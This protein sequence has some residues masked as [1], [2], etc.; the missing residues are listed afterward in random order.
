MPVVSEPP[1]D[2]DNNFVSYLD[3]FADIQQ[4]NGRSSLMP[5]TVDGSVS[6]PKGPLVFSLSLTHGIVNS[7]DIGLP[8]RRPISKQASPLI[9]PRTLQLRD[10]QPSKESPITPSDAVWRNMAYLS[11]QAASQRPGLKSHQKYGRRFRALKPD[12][13]K[14]AKK[15]RKTRACWQC[16]FSKV[17]VSL[18]HGL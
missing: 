12:I 2:I 16:R 6:R 14:H 9:V 17:A 1:T 11:Q 5:V 10:L 7:L 15:M 18:A 8:Q 13:S 3:P 4:E